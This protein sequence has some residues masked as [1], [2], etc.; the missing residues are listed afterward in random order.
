MKTFIKTSTAK[1]EYE[2][3]KMGASTGF[4]FRSRSYS[5]SPTMKRMHVISDSIGV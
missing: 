2:R 3:K 5:R 4:A 1:M